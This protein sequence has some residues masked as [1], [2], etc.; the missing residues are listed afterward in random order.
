ERL[1]QEYRD[2]PKE[3]MRQLGMMRQNSL[4]LLRLV[5]DLLDIIRLEEGQALLE[6]RYLR[7][8]TMLNG[9]VDSM[10]PLAEARSIALENH[11]DKTPVTVFA[12][13]G[14]LEKIFLNLLSNAIKFTHPG[15]QVAVRSEQR[16][17]SITIIIDDTGIGM[18]SDSL[19]HAFDRFRQADSSATRKYGGSG[20]GLALVKELTER[21]EGSVT[22][23]SKPHEGTVVRVT[24]P[25]LTAAATT[26][27]HATQQ[28][29]S[30]IAPQRRLDLAAQQ[31]AVGILAEEP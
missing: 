9:L 31:S 14:A 19:L 23:A 21:H 27:D 8:D 25:M 10:V 26:S 22:I 2:L 20:L 6:R 29:G 24:L 3:V 18:S 1:L 15:G 28:S 16:D 30:E 4:R 17:T 13:R 5:N 11:L 7:L 12:D